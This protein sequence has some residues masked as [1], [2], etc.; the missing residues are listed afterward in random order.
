MDEI[1]RI[2]ELLRFWDHPRRSAHGKANDC[3]TQSN[4]PS[5]SPRRTCFSIRSIGAS[6]SHHCVVSL[7]RSDLN[8]DSNHRGHRNLSRTI[9]EFDALNMEPFPPFDGSR[10]AR[11]VD[12]AMGFI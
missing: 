10:F 11:I 3:H 9:E 1:H 4:A 8:L 6:E 2:F 12:E 5:Q 7:R